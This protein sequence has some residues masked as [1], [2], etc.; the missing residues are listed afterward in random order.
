MIKVQKIVIVRVFKVHEEIELRSLSFSAS[1]KVNKTI[2]LDC[3][4]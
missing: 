1:K 4:S 2:V 3:V